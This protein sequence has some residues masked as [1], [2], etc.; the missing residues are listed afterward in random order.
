MKT[1][2]SGELAE[3]DGRDGRPAY[4]AVDGVVYDVTDIFEYGDHNSHQAGRDLSA[5]F[6]GQHDQS[7]ITKYPV[8]GKLE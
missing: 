1:F 7:F 5:E 2:T 6:H 4:V 3:N 8:V